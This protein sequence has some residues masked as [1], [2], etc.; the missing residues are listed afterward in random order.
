MTSASLHQAV[1]EG[2]HGHQGITP[3]SD[4]DM[5]IDLVVKLSRTLTTWQH[6]LL[7]QTR[8]QQGSSPLPQSMEG[9]GPVMV[10]VVVVVVDR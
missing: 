2:F 9:E 7:L 8:T 6:L 3:Q 1:R 4:D 10:V 5:R